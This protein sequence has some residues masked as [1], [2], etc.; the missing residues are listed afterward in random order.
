MSE[1]VDP[2]PLYT[3]QPKPL[4]GERIIPLCAHRAI[5]LKY[6]RSVREKEGDYGRLLLPDCREPACKRMHT[7]HLNDNH[8]RNTITATNT[9]AYAAISGCPL[10]TVRRSF[11]SARVALALKPAQLRICPHLNLSSSTVSDCFKPHYT[12]HADLKGNTQGDRNFTSACCVDPASLRPKSHIC[13]PCQDI[14]FHTA[15]TFSTIER[16]PTRLIPNAHIELQLTVTIDL[17]PCDNPD[18]L[19]WIAHSHAPHELST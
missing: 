4:L 12:V 2:L 10:E 19:A 11:D 13:L 9:V 8:G 3:K 1:Q 7:I 17:G 15:L 14:G 5:D 6:I 16:K 18:D